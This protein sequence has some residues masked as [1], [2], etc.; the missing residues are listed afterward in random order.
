VNA[1]LKPFLQLC[2]LSGGPQDIPASRALL[3]ITVAA[4]WLVAVA[5][6]WPFYG[7]GPSVLQSIAELA[8]LLAFTRV[9]LIAA[10]HPERF[11]QTATALTATGTLLGIV[12]LPVLYAFYQAEMQD[13]PRDVP[14]LATLVLLGWLLLVYGHIFRH[15]LSLRHLGLGLLVA[16]G[17]MIVG[18]ALLRL[19]FPEAPV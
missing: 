12:M 8:I 1:L 6:A 13:A 7:V 3:L 5:L 2:L 11:T 4:Y 16:L 10:R 15:A 17:L 19:L 9:A 18:Q 14:A